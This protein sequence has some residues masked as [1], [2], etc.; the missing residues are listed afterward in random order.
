MTHVFI[1]MKIKKG[2]LKNLLEVSFGQESLEV[3]AEGH[4][5]LSI[6]LSN[7]V[8]SSQCSYTCGMK[9]MEFKLKKVTDNS[10]WSHLEAVE[11]QLSSAQPMVPLQGNSVPSYPTSS[12]K[13]TD[14]SKVDKEISKDL[15]K[16]KEEGEGALNDLFK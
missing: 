15:S 2:D 8:V 7:K 5:I 10:S 16:D 12:K 11:G 9:K 4:E 13:K 14:F 1:S 6:K 3:V